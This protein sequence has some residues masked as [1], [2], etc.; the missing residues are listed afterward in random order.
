M[1]LKGLQVT[2]APLSHQ[3]YVITTLAQGSVTQRE[4]APFKLS[5]ISTSSTFLVIAGFY[6][7]FSLHHLLVLGDLFRLA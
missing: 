6:S 2:V 3:F 4:T 1:H 7:V 5:L